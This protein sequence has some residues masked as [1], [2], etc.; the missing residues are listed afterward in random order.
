MDQFKAAQR[1]YEHEGFAP[2]QKA[3]LAP[4]YEPNP[5][6]NLYYKIDLK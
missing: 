3:E 6:D 1:F 5:I 4:D 2:I